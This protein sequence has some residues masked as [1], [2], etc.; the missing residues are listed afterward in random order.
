MTKSKERASG[1]PSLGE[2]QDPIQSNGKPADRVC[3]R[4]SVLGISSVGHR[5]ATTSPRRGVQGAKRALHPSAR[6]GR[7]KPARPRRCPEP[8]PA[9]CGGLPRAKAQASLSTPRMGRFAVACWP[10]WSADEYQQRQA[11]VRGG[12]PRIIER[13]RVSQITAFIR[14]DFS[15]RLA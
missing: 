1:R 14:T 15:T 2:P 5:D 13:S 7:D 8:Q 6:P 4:G 12:R 3:G 10:S 11:T 9:P